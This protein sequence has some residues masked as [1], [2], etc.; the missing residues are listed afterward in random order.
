MN[1]NSAF[2]RLPCTFLA[3]SATLFAALFVPAV[4]PTQVQAEPEGPQ[5]N[6]RYIA[7]AVTFLLKN[8]HL[9]RHSVDDEM[10]QRAFDTFIEQLDRFK[11]YFTQA[12]IEALE[13]KRNS[14]DDEVLKGELTFAY[15]AYKTMIE[16]VAERVALVDELLAAEIDFTVDEEL[17]TEP[18]A[19]EYATSQEEIRDRWRKRIKLDLLTHKSDGLSLEEARSKVA[20]RYHTFLRRLK[21]WNSDDL[22][23][24]YLSALTMGYDPH[25]Q[26]MS[27]STL[28]N[29]EI[30]L[31]L[32]LEGI[33]AKLQEEDGVSS[34][35]EIVPGGAADRDGRLKPKDEILGVAE[36][37]DGEIIDTHDMRLNDVVNMIRGKRGTIVRL[38]VKSAGEAESKIYDIIRD[39]IEL[40]EAEAKAEVIEYGKKDDGQPFKLGVID[41]PSFYAD[42]AGERM[43]V[44][45]FK[46]TTRDVRAILETGWTDEKDVRHD[47]FRAQDVDAVILDLRGNGGGSL[48]EAINLTGLFIDRGPVVQVKDAD[49]KVRAQSDTD[50]G[51]AW[52]GPLVVLTDKQS[53]SASEILAGAIQD[54]R[55]GIVVGDTA[56][57]GK[58]TVQS[59]LDLSRTLFRF[60]ETGPKLGALKL[61]MQQF[62]RPN[63]EST[64]ERGVLADIVLPSVISHMDIGEDKL[65]YAL[66]FDKVDAAPY[67]TLDLVTSGIIDGLRRLS[68]ARVAESEDFQ[69]VLKEVDRYEAFKKRKTVPLNEEKFLA[70]LKEFKAEEDKLLEDPESEEHSGIKRDYYLDEAMQI[71]AD[72]VKSLSSLRASK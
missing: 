63:G 50:D 43:G 71:T 39:K 30:M 33:G 64:Q 25:T 26:Y 36:G 17:A 22:M 32:S 67:D 41:L 53:A 15:Q 52:D 58:G 10:S 12:D 37:K 7:R 68:A 24:I 38:K 48:T 55:R 1:R 21:Q 19:I 61:T 69:K 65:D 13:A 66:K 31:K 14:L 18:E 9:S 11:V 34:I 6:D 51:V 42:M 29:F 62:Y 40:K 59:L 35:T 54:Y 16:R 20:K 57:H 8:Q 72:Y 5:Q 56:T 70:Q 28:D 49:G 23:E 46:S 44:A 47:G 60:D 27:P 4:L 2:R 3:V 45:D